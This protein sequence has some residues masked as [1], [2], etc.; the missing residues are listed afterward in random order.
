MKLTQVMLALGLAAVASAQSWNAVNMAPGVYLND[1]CMLDDG[2]H[3]WAVGSTGAGGQTLSLI[4]RTT[5]GGTNWERL[6]FPGQ[7]TTGLNGVWFT[8]PDSGWVVGSAGAIYATSSG[9]NT[10]TLQTS[11]SLRKLNR[12]RFVDRRLGWITGG[13]QDGSSYLLLK[14]TNGGQNW[15]DLSFGS[16][17]Y[18]GQGL[19]FADSLNGWLTGMDNTINPFIQHTTDGGATWTR[20]TTNL[21]TGNGE[22]SAVQ[23]IDPLQGWATTSSLYQTPFGS[24]L[25]TTDGGTTW[26]VQYSTGLTYNYAFDIRDSLHLAIVSTEVIPNSLERVFTSSDGG[27]NWNSYTPPI[28]QYSFGI[29]YRGSDLWVASLNSAII[30]SPDNGNTWQW[31]H[32]APYWNSI[33]WQDSLNGWAV[34]GSNAGTDG[35]CWRSTDAGQTWAHAAGMPGGKQVQFADALHGWMLTEGN[36]GTIR[37]TTNGGQNWSQFGI[38]GSAWIGGMAFASP[39]SGWAFG[40]SGNVRF[41]S[42]GGVTWASRNVGNSAFLETGYF[43]SS[44][45]GWVAGGYGGGNSYIGHTTDGGASWTSQPPAANNHFYASFFLNSRLGWL[46]AVSGYVQGTTDGGASWQMLGQVNRDFVNGILMTDSLNGWLLASDNGNSQQ[47]GLGVIYRTTDGGLSWQSD[48]TA[49]WPNSGLNAIVTHCGKEPWVCGAHGTILRYVPASA[50]RE[51]GPIPGAR[52]MGL[53]VSPNPFCRRTEISYVLT[54]PGRMKLVVYDAL[55][56]QV[57]T[58]VDRQQEP[59]QFSAVWNR[60]D[61]AGRPVPHGAYF[62]RLHAGDGQVTGK[63]LVLD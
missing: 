7:T 14:T 5:D 28:N 17:F 33:A 38:G 19:W 40:G 62:C 6:S 10:W 60:C 61:A 54:R 32:Q 16:D 18:A 56:N 53:Q 31:Q 37:R 36:G 42:N 30:H 21:P 22:V 12:V 8:S 46:G 50:T 20:Q 49:P 45:E 4:L 59:G 47:P 3:G 51:P 9:G 63:L 55:G 23:F 13:W 26:S 11:G 48:W 29:E 41:T 35:Y 34:A 57:A 15:T 43:L 1:L 24:V 25:H 2:L 52:N 39:E 44:T 27:N 58:L